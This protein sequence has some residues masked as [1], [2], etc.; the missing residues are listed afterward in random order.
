MSVLI[1]SLQ[2]VFV[3]LGNI[4]IIL[5]KLKFFTAIVWY[6]LAYVHIV[7]L[8]VWIILLYLCLIWLNLYKEWNIK[9]YEKLSVFPGLWRY[10][11]NQN[12]IKLIKL[13]VIT[14]LMI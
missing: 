1:C 7:L 5:D 8:I 4:C 6:F 11:I 2:I 3:G 13:N 14:F 9:S 12:R 10:K